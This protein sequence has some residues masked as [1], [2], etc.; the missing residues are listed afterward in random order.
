MCDL[1][2]LED[3]KLSLRESSIFELLKQ[4]IKLPK[5]DIVDLDSFKLSLEN[6]FSETGFGVKP[7]DVIVFEDTIFDDWEDAFEDEEEEEDIELIAFQ[8]NGDIF[9]S[10]TIINVDHKRVKPV[11]IDHFDYSFRPYLPQSNKTWEK[12]MTPPPSPVMFEDDDKIHYPKTPT[13]PPPPPYCEKF[14]N[15]ITNGLVGENGK[16]KGK[17]PT[18]YNYVFSIKV[19]Q[20]FTLRFKKLKD[21]GFKIVGE[22]VEETRPRLLKPKAIKPASNY[23][24]QIC[25]HGKNCHFREKGICKFAHTLKE[26]NPITCECDKSTCDKFHPHREKKIEYYRRRHKK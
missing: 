24:T 26:W 25:K 8:D 14:E 1:A 22:P 11:K 23:K 4:P 13:S 12:V 10:S 6:Y 17:I 9:N 19:K 16:I 20:A 21:G 3:I 5:D 15:F 18:P 2:L 7:E